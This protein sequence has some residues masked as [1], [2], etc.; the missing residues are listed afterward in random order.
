METISY[1]NRSFRI[2][3]A[4]GATMFILFYGRTFDL[5]HALSK[6]LFWYAFIVSFCVALLIV[7]I[8]HEMTV[9]LDGRFD[10]RK[11][12]WQ[13]ITYQVFLGIFIPALID[14]IVFTAYFLVLRKNIVHTGFLS[15]DLLRVVFL[16]ALLN[17]YYYI[18]YRL[19]TRKHV[20]EQTSNHSNSDIL[21]IDHNGLHLHLHVKTDVLLIYRDVRVTKVRT[22]NGNEYT[23]NHSL[24]QLNRQYKKQ[25][26]C[27]INQS[28]LVNL[29]MLKGYINVEKRDSYSPIIKPAYR[30]AFPESLSHEFVVTRKY[31]D[32]FRERLADI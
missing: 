24:A 20:H 10:W 17:A 32:D 3:A 13:R 5:H 16:L 15:S 22:V 7:K 8:I 14:V 23:T 11:N 6:P 25:G 18:H 29:Y 26:I 28:F 31:S 1:H 9:Y 27:Q 4:F 21:N 2:L 30:A 19:L 12:F